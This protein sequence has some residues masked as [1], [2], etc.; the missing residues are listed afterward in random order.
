MNY[1][2]RAMARISNQRKANSTEHCPPASTEPTQQVCSDKAHS[3]KRPSAWRKWLAWVVGILCVAVVIAYVG[4]WYQERP[5]AI[6][7]VALERGDPRRAVEIVGTYLEKDPENSR[8]LRLKARLLVMMNQPAEAIRLFEKVGVLSPAEMEAMARAYM[9][10]EQWSAALPLLLKASELQPNNPD[11]WYELTACRVRLGWLQDALQSAEQFVRLSPQKAR[12]YLFI[13][14]I[15]ND[16]KNRSASLEAFARVLEYD[17]EAR[18]L[19]I[20]PEEFFLEYGRTLLVQGQVEQARRMFQRSIEARP[21]AA[22]WAE[23]GRAHI[24]EGQELQA[25]QAW[26]KALELEKLHVEARQGLA[27]LSLARRQ[28]Q[29]ALAWLEPLLESP[30]LRSSTSYLVQRAYDMLG[31]GTKAQQWRERTE[32]LRKQERLMNLVE[33]VALE[34]PHSFW[35]RVMRAYQFAQQGN[36]H[37]AKLLLATVKPETSDEPFVRQLAAALEQRGNLPPLELLPVRHE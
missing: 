22:G 26:K 37:Q 25:E 30:L 20:P 28:P 17:P 27:E 19:Q 8:A 1:P 7:E 15:Q 24:E 29:Q 32:Q 11:I 6:A 35:A 21:T 12:G 13:A 3:E 5:L 9:M 10:Q 4:V 33:R 36:W 18:T 23:F 34:Q 31:D 16:L 14:S 2:G